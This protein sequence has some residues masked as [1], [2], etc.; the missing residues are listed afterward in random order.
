MSCSFRISVD[1]RTAKR[2]ASCSRC[3]RLLE[4]LEVERVVHVGDDDLLRVAQDRVLTH[5]VALEDDDVG[6]LLE[7]RERAVV[8][9]EHGEVGMLE[10][11]GMRARE[12]DL[13]LA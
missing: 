1:D 12:P 7:L 5:Q 11:A 13:V 2:R 4:H 10:R 8:G 6:P 9:L 3:A